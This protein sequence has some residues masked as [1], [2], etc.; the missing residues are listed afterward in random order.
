MA[1]KKQLQLFYVFG[2]ILLSACHSPEEAVQDHLNKGKELFEKGE[3]N[4]ALLELKSATQG[5]QK[6]ETFY[7][8]ALIDEKKSNFRSMRENLVKA[9]EIDPAMSMAR[10]KLVN[11]DLIIG[12]LNNALEN[13]E[14]LLKEKPDD[15]DVS[16]LKATA[17]VKQGKKDQADQFIASILS[18]HPDNVE[19]MSLKAMRLYQDNDLK[20]ALAV[21]SA[22][23]EKDNKNIANR[24]FR[25]EI[26]E[27]LNNTQ[28]MIEDYQEL[29]KQNPNNEKFKLSLMSILANLD[30]LP[31]AESLLKEVISHHK[32]KLEPKI[33]FLEFLHA[34]ANS[35]L[36]G[37]YEQFL[38]DGDV[39]NAQIIELTKWM[40]SAGY[41]DVAEKGLLQIVQTEKDSDL[42][43]KAQT[44]L[45]EIALDRKQYD[46]V[47]KKVDE[48]LK[49]H[50]NFA[51]SLMLKARLFLAQNR[52][53]EGINLLN[54]AA[55]A[56]DT[57]G[58]AYMLLGLAYMAKNEP[59]QADKYFKQALDVN[60]AN[61]NAF[62][63]V[64]ESYL[65]SNQMQIARQY[66][67]KAIKTK[68]N[69]ILFLRLKAEL[70]ITEKR[71]SDALV[72][73]RQLAKFSS[74]K[75]LAF[76][77]EANIL[78]NQGQFAQAIAIYEK[79][80]EDYP[81]TP[82]VMVNLAKAYE[83]LKSVDKAISFF[84]AF[85]QK[86]PG[87]LSS[88]VVLGELYVTNKD[89][90]KAKQ[91]YT[92]QLKKTPHTVQLYLELAKLEADNKHPEAIKDIYLKALEN[93]P[94]DPRISMALAAW[95]E[96]NGDKENARHIYEN[97]LEHQ[98]EN[99]LAINNLAALLVDSSNED[100]LRKGLS[101]AEK[102]KE[103]ET[104]FFQDTF[105]WA[106]VKNGYTSEGLKI[107]ESLVLKEPKLADL[108][109]HLGAA[110]YKNGTK[111][112]AV[113]ELKKAIS[114][115]EKQQS[116]FA[117]MPEAKK[118]LKELDAA[119]KQ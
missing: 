84:E 51:D 112:S 110:Y 9:L 20:G 48:I 60:P 5:E 104:W 103:D 24:L 6:A 108:R 17:L 72:A 44:L 28:A 71:W 78:Q 93:N 15:I 31:E 69:Q 4:K 96:L 11:I 85:Q 32:D 21:Q 55:W 75:A 27:K 118:M 89:F 33:L 47:E 14:K 58:D 2:A 54:N 106:L 43:L 23:L 42:S 38:K 40:L 18:S 99:K 73:V 52:F 12:N 49:E 98:G 7:Y 39:P 16:I 50:P 92:E 37:E 88:I 57:S 87:N 22:A 74:N 26:N 86:H 97:V 10:L 102:L 1:L 59:K 107:L 116:Y 81:D 67:E 46:V 80:L 66:L 79:L 114:L 3:F 35:R 100:D 56:K 83:G 30:K 29:I 109:Y 61:I 77:Y 36:V 68:P 45:A 76:N 62:I 105:A 13:I 94:D 91:L 95:Y 90:S 19:V 111:A 25:I 34:K 63:P 41:A 113:I 65:K 117:F 8:L 101:L 70:E 53:D 115:A 64:Y 82:N 119:E